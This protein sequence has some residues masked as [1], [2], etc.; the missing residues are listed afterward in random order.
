[1]VGQSLPPHPELPARSV[2][3]T[4]ELPGVPHLM[5]LSRGSLPPMPP[6]PPQ[7]LLVNSHPAKLGTQLVLPSQGWSFVLLECLSPGWQIRAG[8]QIT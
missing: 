4:T 7:L 1:M 5:A 8:R 6:F 3:P 2:L